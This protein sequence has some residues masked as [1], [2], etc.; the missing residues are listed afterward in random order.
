MNNCERA[1]VL[2]SHLGEPRTLVY[3]AVGLAELHIARRD[4]AAATSTFDAC[5]AACA[6]LGDGGL[7]GALLQR[8]LPMAMEVLNMQVSPRPWCRVPCAA[9]R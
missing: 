2:A 1:L 3:F 9:Y 4:L 8:V 6:A 7:R 5:A